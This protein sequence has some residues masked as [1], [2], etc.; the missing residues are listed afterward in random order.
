MGLSRLSSQFIEQ[1]WLLLPLL[2]LA[3][4]AALFWV[5]PRL[6]RAAF[7]REYRRRP[8]RTLG[9]ERPRS[10]LVLEARQPEAAHEQENSPAHEA[11]RHAA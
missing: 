1:Q 2:L 6:A 10:A 5:T 8:P 11:E 3:L 9:P 7:M 4:T